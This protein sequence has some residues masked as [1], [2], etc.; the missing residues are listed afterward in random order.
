MST[1]RKQ[2]IISSV[3]VYIGFALGFLNTYLFTRQGGLTK[4]Q[5]GLTNTFIAFGSI[6]FSVASL[7]MP[8]YIGKFF[9]YYKSH[10]P[11]KRNDQLTW[12]LV[13]SCVGFLVVLV[14]GYVFKDFILERFQNSPELPPYYYLTFVF[15]FGYTIYMIMEAYAWMQRKAVLSNFLK[16][17]VYRLFVTLLILLVTFSV[18][19][20]FDVFI[21]LYSFI[22]LA[23]ALVLLIYFAS[24]HKLNF[25]FKTSIVTRKFA[26][27]IA[28]LAS[29]VWGGSLILNTA[30][31][32]DAIVIAAVLPDGMAGVGIFA[33]AMNISSLMQAPQRA[34]ISAA[35]G[36]LSHAWKEKDYQNI[37]RI[38]H[39]S[40]I[41]QLIFASAM[42][43]LIWLNFE[44]GIYTFHLQPAYLQ[45]KWVF[46]FIGLAKI[47]DMG[48]GLNAQI[49]ATSTFWR[50]ELNSSMILVALIFPLNFFLT[51]T[52]GILGPAYSHLIGFTV[53]N[54]VR[55]MFLWRKFKMQPF[56]IKSLYTL[57]LAAFC[58]FIAYVLFHTYTGFIWIVLRS[59]VFVILFASG[60]LALKLSPDIIPVLQTI[61]KRLG[62]GD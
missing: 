40:S 51:R 35:T 27:K 22:Y 5:F 26:K 34:I 31:A 32:F 12:A 55:C 14:G 59:I 8:A 30:S 60:T 39:R 33:L 45:A 1:I 61:R 2:S 36:P 54:F 9:P 28:L 18:I 24:I 19:K 52:Y 15:G 56:T 44:D 3:V 62:F 49:I 13:L 7:G 41:S 4:E 50:F 21:K 46:F 43:C 38:Y 37:N 53:Y 10:L 42:F 57:F 11:D 48:T 25:T 58:F 6:M 16:E 17:V 20:S 47:I 23:I 29:M